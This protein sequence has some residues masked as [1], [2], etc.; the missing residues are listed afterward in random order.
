MDPQIKKI[1]R[2]GILPLII[3]VIGA[4]IIFFTKPEVDVSKPGYITKDAPKPTH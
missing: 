4:L 1:M 2:F 3:L